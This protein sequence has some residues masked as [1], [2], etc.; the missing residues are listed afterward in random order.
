MTLGE[1]IKDA[2]K[3]YRKRSSQPIYISQDLPLL[4]GRTAWDCQTMNH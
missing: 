1:K 3:A 4:N 2:R